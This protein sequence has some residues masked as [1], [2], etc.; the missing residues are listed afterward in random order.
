[1]SFTSRRWPAMGL[2]AVLL[3]FAACA[4]VVRP[5][6]SEQIHGLRGSDVRVVLHSGREVLLRSPYVEGDSV[7]GGWTS[8]PG[9]EVRAAV[10]LAD[11][12]RVYDASPT[13]AE[14]HMGPRN[15]GWGVALLAL[16]AGVALVML[17]RAYDAM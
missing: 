11:I 7:F 14:R 1:M 12:A 13:L 3:A 16:A 5:G 17:H 2:A 4:P 15:M 8:G 10:A 6:A 9:G